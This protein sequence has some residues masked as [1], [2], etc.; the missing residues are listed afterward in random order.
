MS[1]TSATVAAGHERASAACRPLTVGDYVGH[2][3]TIAAREVRR[4]GLRPALERRAAGRRELVG[5]VVAQDPPAGSAMR[6]NAL[7][8][9]Y[10][11]TS[12][13]LADGR[14]P[15]RNGSGM[16]GEPAAAAPQARTSEGRP[17]RGCARAQEQSCTRQLEP[18]EHA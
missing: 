13:L 10:V 12:V 2:G 7:V 17:A 5:D 18:I 1:Q 8:T 6:R 15:A 3:A 11:G 16:A 14:P 4:A 9:L